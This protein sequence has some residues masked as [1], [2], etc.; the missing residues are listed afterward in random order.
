MDIRTIVSTEYEER[1]ASTPMS[2]VVGTFEDREVTGIVVTRDGEYEGVLTRRQLTA[3]RYQPK[4][5]VGSLVWHVPRV[6]PTADV[7]DV[8]RLMIDSESRLLPVFEADRLHGVVTADALLEAVLPPDPA[9]A[10]ARL[11]LVR[12]KRQSGAS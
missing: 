7:R 10:R 4:Q 11:G 6:E 1:D 3:S 5:K 2:K 12:R 8:A 9:R